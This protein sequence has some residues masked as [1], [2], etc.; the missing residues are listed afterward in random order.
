[1]GQ[2]ELSW[3]REIL[4]K[5]RAKKPLVHNITNF[6]VMN[7]TANALLALGASPIMAHAVEELEDLIKIAD[8]LVVNI[9]TLDEYWAY[10]AIKAVTI[11]KRYGKPVVLDPVGAGATELRTRISM[12]IANTG[13]S[14][15]KG[16]YGEI[17]A[18]LGLT[19]KT[20][21]VDRL[22][23]DMEMAEKLVVSCARRYKSVVAITGPVDIVSDGEHVYT[24]KTGSN[25]S[26]RKLDKVIDRVTG[27]GCIVTVIIGAYLGVEE[28]LKAS[29]AGLSTFRLAATRAAEESEYPGSFHVKIY[30]WLYRLSGEDLYNEVEVLVHEA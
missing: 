14:V 24:I 5:L 18:L 7:T 1:M 12:L 29:I 10:S 23:Y 22:E 6:V 11:A 2:M 20:K 17:A 27:L 3:L 30:D 13:V 21:G 19:G 25:E 15:I 28:P 9:G 16:N 8:S 4:G 26:Q